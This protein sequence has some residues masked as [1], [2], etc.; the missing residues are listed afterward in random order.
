MKCPSVLFYVRTFSLVF[1]QV[2]WTA[3]QAFC[4]EEIFIKLSSHLFSANMKNKKNT[5]TSQTCWLLFEI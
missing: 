5:K 1:Y 2:I 4:N 3:F